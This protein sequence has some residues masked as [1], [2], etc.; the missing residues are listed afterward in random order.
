[1]EVHTSAAINSQSTSTL[2]LPPCP[3]AYDIA[4]TM[5]STSTSAIVTSPLLPT[6]K[7]GQTILDISPVFPTHV[8]EDGLPT[9]D[10]YCRTTDLV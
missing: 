5:Q 3:P 8:V 4:V 7:Y 2:H 6:P 10:E 9:Y 1:M